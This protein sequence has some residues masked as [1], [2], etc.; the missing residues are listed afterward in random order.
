[1]RRHVDK[2]SNNTSSYTQ[3]RINN[4]DSRSSSSTI[5]TKHVDKKINLQ[6]TKGNIALSIT[7]KL[8]PCDNKISQMVLTGS[9]PIGRSPS[10]EIKISS[11][12]AW[13]TMFKNHDTN[14]MKSS[15]SRPSGSTSNRKKLHIE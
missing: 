2:I 14:S 5:L 13:G 10:K 4:P 3:A 7:P 6:Y 15:A 1:M 12:S 9:S 8:V 11:D